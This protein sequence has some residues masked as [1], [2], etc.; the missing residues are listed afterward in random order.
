MHAHLQQRV[1]EVMGGGERMLQ[2]CKGQ[3]TGTQRKAMLLLSLHHVQFLV[4]SSSSLPS[5]SV[6]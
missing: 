1:Y 2:G 3:L 5:V 4:S 6:L